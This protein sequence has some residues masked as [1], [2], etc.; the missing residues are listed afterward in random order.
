MRHRWGWLLLVSVLITW[1]SPQ[2]DMLVRIERRLASEPD[3]AYALKA[4]VQGARYDDVWHA[5]Q[6]RYCYRLSWY[7]S[8]ERTAKACITTK[9]AP[10]SRSRR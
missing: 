8:E 6:T 9:P 5:P 2:P 4:V 3:T 7:T 10:A 1:R